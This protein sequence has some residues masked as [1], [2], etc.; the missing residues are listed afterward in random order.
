[1]LGASWDA[2]H[3]L[4]VMLHRDRVVKVGGADT[5]LLEWIAANDRAEEDR[6]EEDRAEEEAL[7]TFGG[8]RPTARSAGR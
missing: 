2:E 7:I 3:G 1:M 8:G 4:G 5:A 6:A